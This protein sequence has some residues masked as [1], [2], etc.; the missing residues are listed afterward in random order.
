[1]CGICGIKSSSVN[2]VKNLTNKISI[3]TENLNFR[4][5]DQ[6]GI[7]VNNNENLAF[8][9]TRLAIIDLSENGRQ[10]M[11]SNCGR[12][13]ITF[14]GE[15]Y[16]HRKLRQNLLFKFGFDAWRGGSDSETLVNL[17]TFYS[18]DEVLTLINGM[19]AFAVYDFNRKKLTLI[20]DRMGEKPLYWGIINQALYF[21][22]TPTAIRKMCLEKLKVSKQS[23]K[24]FI[25]YGY[26]GNEKSIFTK[27]CK[28]PA[29]TYKQFDNQLNHE[30]KKYWHLFTSSNDLKSQSID[31]RSLEDKLFASVQA[32]LEADVPVG[33][34]LSGGIDSSLISA[35]AMRLTNKLRTFS[36]GYNDEEYD[37]SRYAEKIASHIGS[38]HLTK[39]VTEKEMLEVIPYIPQIWDEPF[40]D[41]SQIPTYLVSKMASEHVK[42]VLSGDGGDELFAGYNRHNLGLDLWQKFNWI[43]PKFKS[44]FFFFAKTL[45]KKFINSLGRN[46]PGRFG[47]TLA[48][49]KIQKLEGALK[50]KDFYQYYSYLTKVSDD[51][52][53][54]YDHISDNVLKGNIIN[55]ESNFLNE[56]LLMDQANYLPDDILVKV[57]RASMYNGLEV[58]VPFLD[59]DVVRFAN[60][61]DSFSKI[62][63]GKSK[64]PLRNLLNKFVD[65]NLIERPKMGFGIPIDKW[66]HGELRE[67][68]SHLLDPEKLHSLN[69]FKVNK[70]Q[71]MFIEHQKGKVSYHNQLWPI[72][73]LV[74]WLDYNN[75]SGCNIE[76]G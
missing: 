58:R 71:N 45:G 23:I 44:T 72:L 75:L 51:D 66:L 68:A 10:P 53:L 35:I 27:I 14:N 43:H 24:M 37:E 12:F 46:L 33:S 55:S 31:Q 73:M 13:A 52:I 20:R 70:I 41:S 48:F 25:D 5:R 62:K 74:Q 56:M 8:G 15:I 69:I 64:F 17:F 3:G 61:L 54:N 67:W 29:G 38:N 76:W 59:L 39:I 22:S 65:S 1:M 28:I 2:S 30:E 6:N 60:S 57:D 11:I 18:I 40:A 19:F 63:N 7:Y 34:F 4:G 42:V 47:T 21:A 50:T 16:N 26:V 32:M 49:E 9:H 36:I